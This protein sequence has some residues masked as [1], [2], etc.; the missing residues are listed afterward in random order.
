MRKTGPLSLARFLLL[1]G[2]IAE[3]LT[4]QKG[5]REGGGGMVGRGGRPFFRRLRS[6][7]SPLPSLSPSQ[8]MVRN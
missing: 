2:G 3:D 7:N 6:C 8:R 4:G 5:A 1:D